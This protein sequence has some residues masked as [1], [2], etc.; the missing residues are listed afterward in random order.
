L[1]ESRT[2]AILALEVRLS[3]DS[4]RSHPHGLQI[5][6]TVSLMR[7]GIP[8]YLTICYEI[9]PSFAFARI[10]ISVHHFGLV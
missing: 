2:V 6:L 10:I 7:F 5:K 4:A 1:T 3:Y 8:V 9:S